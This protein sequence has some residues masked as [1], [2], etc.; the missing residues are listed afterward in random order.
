M[1]RLKFGIRERAMTAAC[2]AMLGAALCGIGAEASKAKS[3]AAKAAK[4]I[5]GQY[6]KKIVPIISVGQGLHIGAAEVVGPKSKVKECKAVAQLEADFT[7]LSGTRI[8]ALVPI[9]T[10]NVV[11]NL[12]RVN[13]VAVS[14]YGDVEPKKLF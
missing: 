7:K 3:K 10:E 12:K 14:M 11:G 5:P 8:K 1:K 2:V 13:Q 6:S 9:S 4:D